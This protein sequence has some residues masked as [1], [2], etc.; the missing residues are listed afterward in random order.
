M[1]GMRNHKVYSLTKEGRDSEYQ[2]LIDQGKECTGHDMDSECM[3]DSGMTH[4]HLDI[5]AS[6]ANR[7]YAVM[8]TDS[9]FGD[10]DGTDRV[11]Y[12]GS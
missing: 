5:L 3:I 10:Y 7:T 8:Y 1:N 9:R 6:G 11:E 4:L 12:P 2:R